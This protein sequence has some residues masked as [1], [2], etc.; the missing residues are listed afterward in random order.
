MFVPFLPYTERMSL[1]GRAAS[2][3][4]LRPH[5]G[6][7]GAATRGG[8]GAPGLPELPDRPGVA[9]GNS[10]GLVRPNRDGGASCSTPRLGTHGGHFPRRRCL[11]WCGTRCGDGRGGFAH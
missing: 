3:R 9:Q 6:G 4:A 5:R 10:I 2:H 7:P 8:G 11:N 1:V